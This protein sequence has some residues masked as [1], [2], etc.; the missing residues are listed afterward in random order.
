MNTVRENLIAA[1]AMIDTPEKYRSGRHIRTRIMM[2]VRLCGGF[3]PEERVLRNA[4][5]EGFT[6]LRSFEDA[7]TTMHADI[8][9][10][11]DRAISSQPIG[12]N[13]GRK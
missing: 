2:A 8:M 9:A 10:L 5:P 4:V 11:F 7:D 13:D 1:R 3:D 6:S 12:D